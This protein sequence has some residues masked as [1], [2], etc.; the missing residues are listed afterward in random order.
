MIG[1]DRCQYGN[2]WNKGR[3]SKF[4]VILSFVRGFY[5]L[6]MSQERQLEC[7]GTVSERFRGFSGNYIFHGFSSHKF[8]KKVF[9]S[10]LFEVYEG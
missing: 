4:V 3:V 7:S 8:R 9:P 1:M 2:P 5:F 6:D 10:T